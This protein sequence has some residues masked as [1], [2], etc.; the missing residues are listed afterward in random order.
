MNYRNI[1]SRPLKTWFLLALLSTGLLNA[2]HAQNHPNLAG[3]V[4]DVISTTGF[5]YV[6]VATSQGKV[7]AAGVGAMVINKGDNVSFET[8]VAMKNYHSKN[9]NRDF[10]LVYFV[11]QFN[12]DESAL[13]TDKLIEQINAKQSIAPAVSKL[14]ASTREVKVGENL[15]E[16]VLDGLQGEQKKLS[17]YQG[18]PLIINVWASWCGPCRAEMGSL[19][20]LADKYNGK[21]FNIIGISTDDY[22]NNAIAALNQSKITFENFI[23]HKLLLEKML[24]ANTIPLTI[25]VDEQGRVLEKIRGAREWDGSKMTGAIGTTFQV[26]L[27][28]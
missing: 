7:W 15:R 24:G 21:Q 10:P 14:L 22:R 20:R 16:A 9:L 17:D 1:F 23:D 4:M 13:T 3:K 28:D 8:N 27:K 5:T 12:T 2:T 26:R 11:K 6:E 18:K 25:L 19:Q